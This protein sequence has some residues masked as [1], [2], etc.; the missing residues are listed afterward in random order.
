LCY[1]PPNAGCFGQSTGGGHE[2]VKIAPVAAFSG[3]VLFV[4]ILVYN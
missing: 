4:N 3:M 2:R 1:F